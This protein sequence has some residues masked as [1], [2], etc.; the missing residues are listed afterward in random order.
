MPIHVHTVSSIRFLICIYINQSHQPTIGDQIIEWNGVNLCN[1]SNEEVQQILLSQFSDDEVEIIYLPQEKSVEAYGQNSY[2]QQ[3]QQLTNLKGHKYDDDTSRNNINLDS[4]LNG[5]HYNNHE[6]LQSNGS[7][8][9]NTHETMDHKQLMAHTQALINDF[10]K[11]N[12]SIQNQ[13]RRK[14]SF[15]SS[16]ANIWQSPKDYFK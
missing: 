5:S 10:T 4:D 16:I 15:S 2:S 3:Q 1:R 14:K 8:Q 6:Q 13:T 7:F 12:A 9:E 11:T